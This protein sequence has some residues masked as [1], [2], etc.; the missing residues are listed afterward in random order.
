VFSRDAAEREFEA[1]KKRGVALIALGEPEY[2]ARLR[3][4]DD[5]PPLIWSARATPG[6]QARNSP[7]VSRMNWPQRDLSLYPASPAALT[8][9]R[10][11]RALAPAQSQCRRA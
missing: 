11:A 10:I 3:M 2:P 4:I 6:P 5:P 8:L 7:S 1:S 9:R